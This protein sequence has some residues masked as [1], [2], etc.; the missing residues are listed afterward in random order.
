[1]GPQ[2][3]E[4]KIFYMIVIFSA[5]SKK[6]EVKK[7][8]KTVANKNDFLLRLMR[9]AMKFFLKLFVFFLRKIP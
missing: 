1:M 8:K 4:I 3:P 7:K 6:E 5:T 2:K 9:S